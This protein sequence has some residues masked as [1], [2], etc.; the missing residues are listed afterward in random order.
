MKDKIK[1]SHVHDKER[2][3]LVIKDLMD[4]HD[5]DSD[6]LDP[7]AYINKLKD[8]CYNE[9]S[10]EKVSFEDLPTTPDSAWATQKDGN[11]YKD[12]EIQPMEYSMANTFN[13]LQHTAIKYISRYKFKHEDPTIDLEKAK[14]CIDML[15]EYESGEFNK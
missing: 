12:M 11:H 9:E 2:V 1:L 4:M 10:K 6:D 3:I 7:D 15:I 14:H 5:I 13:A 8:V